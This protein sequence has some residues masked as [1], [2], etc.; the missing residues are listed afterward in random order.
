MLLMSLLDPIWVIMG[1][2][3]KSQ[4][5]RRR[6]EGVD[7][8]KTLLTITR[9]ATTP[10]KCPKE[11]RLGLIAIGLTASPLGKIHQ[12]VYS[13]SGLEVTQSLPA[14][15][16]DTGNISDRCQTK[17]RS[18]VLGQCARGSNGSGRNLRGACTR[19][20]ISAQAAPRFRARV[21]VCYSQKISAERI[22][23]CLLT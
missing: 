12:A 14:H 19:S 15:N 11:Y 2:V 20:E 7:E 17:T 8:G 6:W 23:R 1:H 21:K 5:Q 9:A 4:L 22:K 10:S 3:G 13:G 16:I 18:Q